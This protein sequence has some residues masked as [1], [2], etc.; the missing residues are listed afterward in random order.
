[1]GPSSIA[2]IVGRYHLG[3][4]QAG[5]PFHFPF[6]GAG[7]MVPLPV[8]ARLN[9]FATFVG[10]PTFLAKLGLW[11]AAAMVRACLG[12]L[13]GIRSSLKSCGFG[14]FGPIGLP[15]QWRLG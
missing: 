15:F 12:D 2:R 8:S 10:I 3:L 14:P 9:S 1:M 13:L 7:R 5:S 6:F 4:G 11:A